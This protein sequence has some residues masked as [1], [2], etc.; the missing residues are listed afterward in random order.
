[1]LTIEHTNDVPIILDDRQCSQIYGKFDTA[2]KPC[3]LHAHVPLLFV[4]NKS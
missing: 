1:M 3:C 2:V 4:M